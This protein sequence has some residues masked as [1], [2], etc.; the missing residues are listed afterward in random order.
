MTFIDMKGLLFGQHKPFNLCTNKK[1]EHSCS[2]F[3][4]LVTCFMLR[5]KYRPSNHFAVF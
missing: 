5:R 2:A 4:N 3:L 1:A